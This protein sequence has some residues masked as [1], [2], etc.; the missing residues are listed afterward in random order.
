[1]YEWYIKRVRYSSTCAFICFSD[2][3]TYG[4]APAVNLHSKKEIYFRYV[5]S[6]IRYMVFELLKNAMR[7]MLK[8]DTTQ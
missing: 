5:P 6:H 8:R 1:M 2:G 7:G 4:V 3:R